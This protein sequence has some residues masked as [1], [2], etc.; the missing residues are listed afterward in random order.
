MLF[1]KNKKISE[2]TKR[3]ED[4]EIELEC[5]RHLI[6]A[7]LT[8]V[9]RLRIKLEIAEKE[10]KYKTSEIESMSSVILK[11]MSEINRLNIAKATLSKVDEQPKKRG[12]KPKNV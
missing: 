12:R 4:L 2:L 8:D 6:T 3:V 9:N 7:Y 11:N 5:K 10:I 1:G